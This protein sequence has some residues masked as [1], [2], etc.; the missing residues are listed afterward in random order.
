M[1]PLQISSF[2]SIPLVGP[3]TNPLEGAALGML[4]LECFAEAGTLLTMAVIHHGELK[5]LKYSNDA[6]ENAC[7]EFDELNLKPTYRIL[8][9]IPG[10]SNAISIAKIRI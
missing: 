2:L 4:L 8:W 1:V 10:R 9:A 5:T 7:M 3:G 6:F